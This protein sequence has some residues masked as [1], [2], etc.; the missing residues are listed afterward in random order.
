MQPH[1]IVRAIEKR[2]PNTTGLVV[3]LETLCIDIRSA[4]LTTKQKKREFREIAGKNSH[5]PKLA[6][7]K[8]EICLGK[9][10]FMIRQQTL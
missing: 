10:F 6:T 5:T 4:I 9:L 3:E 7:F 1:C 8:C 2:A